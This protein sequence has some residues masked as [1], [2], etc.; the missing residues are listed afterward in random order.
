M[1][2]TIILSN[3]TSTTAATET[4]N[5]WTIKHAR[6]IPIQGKVEIIETMSVHLNEDNHIKLI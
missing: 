1:I 6:N 4:K 2:Y 5:I 3:S